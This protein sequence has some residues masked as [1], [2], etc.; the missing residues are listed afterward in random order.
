MKL[1]YFDQAQADEDDFLLQMAKGQAYV[2]PKCLLG[3]AVIMHDIN[4]GHNP[5]WN[6]NGPRER[7]ESVTMPMPKE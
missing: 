2:P 4:K 6:C 1:H 7:C 3:G 5:C